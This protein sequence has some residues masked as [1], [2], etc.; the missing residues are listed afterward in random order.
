MGGSGGSTYSDHIGRGGQAAGPSCALLT[1]DVPVS[2]PIATVV[3]A[4]TV[5]TICEVLL[6]GAPA[7]LRVYVRGSGDLLGAIGERWQE[8]TGCIADGY[9]YEAEV[10]AL[11]PAVRVRIRPR[12]TYQLTMPFPAHVVPSGPGLLTAGAS[13]TL[14]LGIDRK[15]I[16]TDGTSPVG[17]IPEEPAALPDAVEIK[18]AT[19]A[20]VTDPTTGAVDVRQR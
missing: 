9:R 11:F 15:V 4:L 17:T 20:V 14:E 13:Y 2:S 6:E 8:L 1:F 3:A 16:A 5:G 19:I 10:I 12:V 18:R 7:Q